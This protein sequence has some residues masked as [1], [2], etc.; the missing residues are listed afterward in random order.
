MDRTL[1]TPKVAAIPNG[2][3]NSFTRLWQAGDSVARQRRNSLQLALALLLGILAWQNFTQ[4]NQ[5]PDAFYPDQLAKG[6]QLA[7]GRYNFFHPTLLLTVTEAATAALYPAES[8]DYWM[9]GR[10]VSALFGVMVVWLGFAT[11]CRWRG[12]AAG[13]LGGV[14][15]A[16]CPILVIHAH[17]FKEDAA[18]AF[19][20][21]AVVWAATIDA[22]RR[23][24]PSAALLGI[25]VALASSGKYLGFTTLPLAILLLG[26]HRRKDL[27]RLWPA[28]GLM[29]SVAAVGFALFNH[30][31]WLSSGS[32]KAGVTYE[33]TH[34]TTHHQGLVPRFPLWL[35]VVYLWAQAGPFVLGLALATPLAGSP[36]A[37]WS[38]ARWLVLIV[39]VL[40]FL[41]VTASAIQK[42]RYLLPVTLLA[43]LMAVDGLWA[44]HARL[45]THRW[46][47]ALVALLALAVL[48][49]YLSGTQDALQRI[50]HDSRLL[51]P[52]VV[53]QRLPTGSRIFQSE[54]VGL[55]IVIYDGEGRPHAISRWWCP[56]F[57]EGTLE[58]LTERGD[59]FA[60][61]A[62]AYGR[63]DNPAFKPGTRDGNPHPL[64]A[65]DFYRQLFREAE[66][67]WQADGDTRSIT[68]FDPT[69]RLYDLRGLRAEPGTD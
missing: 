65:R 25:A 39:A 51:L 31:I 30:P 11:L 34:V 56:N 15:L 61:T 22:Q 53:V 28:V 20:L 1:T 38:R 32:W 44:L 27:P 41:L 9:M 48:S 21:F 24:L 54:D 40:L 17:F 8:Q 64:P 58:D 18:L 36:Q 46:R 5:F 6:Q 26:V 19:G 29:L 45:A 43:T 37:R 4:H 50:A 16:C 68:P 47:T 2:T 57:H 10:H 13:L 14:L 12:T 3:G 49:G 62:N 66:L 67:V 35:P 7:Y 52:G 23:S 63:F 69:V 60:V 42:P 55:P 33:L 59:F